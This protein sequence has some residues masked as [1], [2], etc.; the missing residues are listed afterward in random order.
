[1]KYLAILLMSL[2]FHQCVHSQEKGTG[3]STN[4]DLFHPTD[5]NIQFIGRIEDSDP[6]FIKFTYPGVQGSQVP[7]SK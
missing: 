6:N 4:K 5:T 1:M 7:R 2:F 3:K